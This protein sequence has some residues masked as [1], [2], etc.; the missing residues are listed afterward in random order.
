MDGWGPTTIL[1]STEDVAAL[2]ETD[3]GPIYIHGSAELALRLGE[4]GLVDR[5]NLLLFP[6]LLP[7][8][9]TIFG[10]TGTDRRTLALRESAA[11]VNGVVKL[12]YDVRR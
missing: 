2:K 5:Y 8:G 12:V 6:Y 1:R 3:G 9:K 11:Y 10:S 7:G 4:A